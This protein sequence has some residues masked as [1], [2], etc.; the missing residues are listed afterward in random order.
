M[1]VVAHARRTICTSVGWS[2]RVWYPTPLAESLL[3]LV[4]P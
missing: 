3:A 2:I 4:E 1:L